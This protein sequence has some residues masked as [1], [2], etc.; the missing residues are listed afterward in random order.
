MEYLS[1]YENIRVK[2]YQLKISVIC[3]YDKNDIQSI[4]ICFDYIPNL[5]LISLF[6]IYIFFLLSLFPVQLTPI[7]NFIIIVIKMNY[8][9]CKLYQL[10]VWLF[11]DIPFYCFTPFSPFL[12]PIWIW[13]ANLS[14]YSITR[15]LT[16][17]IF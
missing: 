10:D 17:L 12:F 6:K 5:Y 7:C 11:L 16:P 1:G 9:P 4:W 8:T 15:Y 2:E 3:K 14:F 13:H